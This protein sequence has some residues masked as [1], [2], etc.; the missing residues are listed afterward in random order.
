MSCHSL[1]VGYRIKSDM[2]ELADPCVETE[3]QSQLER[4]RDPFFMWYAQCEACNV[5]LRQGSAFFG[6]TL[7]MC[8]NST[9][10]ISLIGRCLFFHALRGS[11]VCSF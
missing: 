3:F 8:L 9:P 5:H 6:L 2:S 7:W 1:R 11:L 4:N 10:D